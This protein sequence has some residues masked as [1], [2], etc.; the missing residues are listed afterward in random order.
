MAKKA[1][2]SVKMVEIPKL[3]PARVLATGQPIVPAAEKKQIVSIIMEKGKPG[4]QSHKQIEVYSDGKF[5]DGFHPIQADIIFNAVLG[6]LGSGRG[7]RPTGFAAWI[8]TISDELS[9]N[10]E[11]KN[12]SSYNV[13]VDFDKRGGTL[14]YPMEDLYEICRIRTRNTR[15]S[16]DRFPPERTQPEVKTERTQEVE[17]GLSL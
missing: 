5:V 3:P 7:D 16:H 11:F 10:A 4:T 1:A 13:I 8:S 9:D 2:K 15:V 17:I 6:A 14:V 12:L